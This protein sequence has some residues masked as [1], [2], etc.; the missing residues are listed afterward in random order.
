MIEF[1][2]ATPEDIMRIVPQEQQSEPMALGIGQEAVLAGHVTLDKAVVARDEDV[3]LGVGGVTDIWPGVGRIW[4]L[5]SQ[6]LLDEHGPSLAR[7]VQRGVSQLWMSRK[8]H[9]LECTVLV[10]HRDGIDFLVW[11][12][13][14]CEGT[15]RKY[16]PTGED[17]YLYAKVERDV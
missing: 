10:S 13:F 16:T 14:T 12:G 15:M 2:Q 8:Y 11:L 4:G 7:R 17:A 3:I 9:R 6:K 1:I 5:F